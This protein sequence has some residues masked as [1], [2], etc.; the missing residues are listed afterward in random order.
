MNLKKFTTYLLTLCLVM[1]VGMGSAI[2]KGGKSGKS[3]KS[4]IPAQIADLQAQIDNLSTGGDHSDILALIADLQAQINALPPPGGGG[5]MSTCV[6]TS[7]WGSI[8][9]GGVT[10]FCNEGDLA[11][12][13]G[14]SAI[15]AWGDPA[16]VNRSEPYLLAPNAW[17]WTVEIGFTEDPENAAF[18]TQYQAYAVCVQASN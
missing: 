18:A 4:G 7:E 11:I 5:A 17:G 9:D 16:V 10:A 8:D 1:F 15:I 2:A 13:G 12:S 6:A 14:H 3:G